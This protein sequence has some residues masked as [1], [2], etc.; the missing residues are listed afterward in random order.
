M[1]FLWGEDRLCSITTNDNVGLGRHQLFDRQE[2]EKRIRSALIHWLPE[3][4]NRQIASGNRNRFCRKFHF[5][6]CNLLPTV[7]ES[8][9]NEK[10]RATEIDNVNTSIDEEG[11]DIV[12]EA[13]GDF[14][15]WQAGVCLCLSLLKLPVAWHQLS[16]VFLAPP[17]GHFHCINEDLNS[18]IDLTH[19]NGSHGLN[20][21]CMYN[22]TSKDGQTSTLIPCTKWKYDHS[23]FEETI[24]TEWNLVCNRSQLANV[25]QTTF[26]LGILLGNVLFG[27]FA[28]RFGRKKPLLLAILLQIITGIGAAFVPWFE[29]FIV[30]RFILAFATGGTMM[31]SFVICM[32]IV[33]G[34]WRTAAPVL[35]HLPFSIGHS[36]LSAFSY[37]FRNWRHFQLA[38]SLPSILFLSYWWL[39]PESPRWLLAVG[40]HKE[41]EKLLDSAAKTNGR[42][43]N[44]AAMAKLQNKDC[45]QL[46]NHSIK[47]NNAENT[48]NESTK[49]QTKTKKQGGNLLDL[50]RTPNLRRKTLV[51]NFNWLVCGLG[52]FGVAQYMGRLGGDIFINVAISGAMETPGTLICIF[53]MSYLGRRNTLLTSQ[54][55]GGLSCLLIMLVP[56]DMGWLQVVLSS[57]GLI[58]M[59]SAFP[60]SYLYTAEL[61]PTV[62]RNAAVGAAS[63]CARIGSMTA[64]FITTL[65]SVSEYIPPLILGIFPLVA[66]LLALMLPETLNERLPDTLQEGEDF[67]KKKPKKTEP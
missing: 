66:G 13:L 50:V 23:I 8:E 56:K 43:W 10:N 60:T 7:T 37:E 17:V 22:S 40:H 2:T 33:G 42:T 45:L 41:T 24:I 9:K 46:T 58:G 47:S 28:D 4:K 14:G 35:Y 38:I 51:M 44:K 12:A 65:D 31:T 36:S 11:E 29:A 6:R 27:V 62:I 54:L 53:A 30:L 67:G 52:F 25:A 61:F 63:M 1:V 16:I 39:V 59:S 57:L 19:L 48:S 18:T 64:P 34:W 26:M 20:N 32:E 15:W 21:Q 3:T 55:V 5:G 49:K